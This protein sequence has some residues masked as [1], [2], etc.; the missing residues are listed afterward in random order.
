MEFR[1]AWVSSWHPGFFTPEEADETI[2][3]A[4]KAGLNALVV[5]V[6]KCGDA[7]YRSDI[8]PVGPEVPAGFD[9]LAYV[10][11]NAHAEGMQVHAWLVV[12]RVWKGEIPDGVSGFPL[13]SNPETPVQG[14]KHVLARH[15]EWRNVTY[16]GVSEHEEGVYA[17]PGIAGYREHFASVCEDVAKRYAVDGIHF[18]YVRYPGREWGYS[19][20]ALEAYRAET[21]ATGK[22]EIDDPKWLAWKRDQVTALVKLVREKVKAV[23]PDCKIQ[24]STIPWGECPQDFTDSA[25][26]NT[27]CQDWRMWMEQGLIDENCPMVYSREYEEAGAAHFRGWVDGVKRWSYGRPAYVGIAAM[28]LNAEQMLAQIEAVRKAGLPG[29]VLFSFDKSD[30]RA[31]KAEGLGKGLYP[32]PKLPVR[33]WEIEHGRTRIGRMDAEGDGLGR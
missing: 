15:P 30:S 12:N 9:P 3:L 20:L 1:G 16:D 5:E 11:E 10:V 28:W 33:G 19:P 4:K 21:G 31:E 8:E 24:A 7:Y 32:A 22:P 25:A 14:P 13:R 23:A 17:D 27:V 2:A 6:R 18:D 29:F 26:Y